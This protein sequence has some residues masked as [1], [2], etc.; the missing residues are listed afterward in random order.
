MR[1]SVIANEKG[2]APVCLWLRFIYSSHPRA[3]HAPCVTQGC[4][5]SESGCPLGLQAFGTID[6]IFEVEAA[7]TTRWIMNGRRYL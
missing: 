2:F 6:N 3:P 1:G 5:F 4:D 7:T